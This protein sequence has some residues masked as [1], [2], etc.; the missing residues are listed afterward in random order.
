MIYTAT[1]SNLISA[2]KSKMPLPSS[3]Y[4]SIEILR[5]L[6]KPAPILPLPE[7]ETVVDSQSDL[8]VIH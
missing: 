2:S 5:I 1:L 4:L 7:S 6:Q 8:M 3:P